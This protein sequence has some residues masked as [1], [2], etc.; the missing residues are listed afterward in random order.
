[1]ALASLTLHFTFEKIQMK[2]IPK[3]VIGTWFGSIATLKNAIL[4]IST[5]V[6]SL[7]FPFEL[8]NR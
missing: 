7:N 5:F 2:E 6:N 1:M 4:S 3:C 8:G